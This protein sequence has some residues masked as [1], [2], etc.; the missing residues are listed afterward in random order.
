VIVISDSKEEA[1]V[2]PQPIVEE[3]L[4][5]IFALKPMEEDELQ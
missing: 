1:K 4:Q 3:Q 5:S 2:G